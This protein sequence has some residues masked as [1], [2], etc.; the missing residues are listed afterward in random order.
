[1]AHRWKHWFWQWRGVAIAT[2]TVALVVLLLRTAGMLQALEWRAYD[3]FL[4]WRPQ[5]T[6]PRIA[7]VGI[8]EED[9]SLLGQ[10]ILPDEI[11]AKVIQTLRAQKPRAIGLDIYRDVPVEP[12]HAELVEVFTSTPNLVGIRK[13][14]GETGRDTVAA[15]PILAELGQVGV[16][17]LLADADN[18]V[19]RGMLQATGPEGDLLPSFALYLALLY[20]DAEGVGPEMIGE[21]DNWQ[22]GKTIFRPFEPNDGAYVRANAE[23]YQTLINYRGGAQLFETVPLRAV[24]NDELP[25]DWARDRIILV[26]PV[27]ESFKDLFFTP[28]S[29]ELLAL[30]EQMP[31]VEI[32]A[33]LTS[34]ILSA[35]LDGR[36]LIRSWPELLEVL[37]II[38][39]A[40]LGAVLTWVQR[41]TTAGFR[42]QR[43]W[44]LCLAALSL[45]A[46]THALLVL[47]WWVP[48]VPPLIALTGATVG[49][50]AYLAHGANQIRRTF[51]RYLSDQVV[52]NLLE[53]PEKLKLGGENRVIT[54]L[55]SDIRGFTSLSERLRPEQ[56]VEVLNLYLGFMSDVINRYGGTIDEFMGDG[57]L[58]LFGAPNHQ[59]DAPDRAVA[60]AI[61]M[62]QVMPQVNQVMR[63]RSFPELEMGIGINTGEVV[64]GN[65]GSEKRTKYSV[66][67]SAVNLAYRIE[68]YTTGG[69]ILVSDHTLQQVVSPVQVQDQQTVHPKGVKLPL[70]IHDIKGIGDPYNLTLTAA[71]MQMVTLANPITVTYAILDGKQVNDQTTQG[72]LVKLSDKGAWLKPLSPD[73]TLTKLTN[74]R[75]SVHSSH[76]PAEVSQADIYAK[77]QST[78]DASQCQIVFTARSQPVIDWIKSRLAT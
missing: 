60:C 39:W 17:D 7:I 46:I 44:S 33:N 67:G 64:V 4:R 38:G 6:D 73:S 63:D 52:A 49:V 30:P 69:Q 35:A 68:S 25:P 16:N 14:A 70:T 37:W 71:A 19:R 1:M 31:G 42:P 28:Y 26:G 40:A 9:V 75:L 48:V 27:S 78:I 8:D 53:Y 29:S 72:M 65:I 23:G 20:L 32:H 34:Q 58:V 47:G 18:T 62:Q 5:H 76:A 77:V 3:Q 50:T 74:L 66:I 57:I 61:A 41:D 45:V 55:T 51:G 12:G 59:S 21:T 22:L 11:Y 10:S 2:P 56:V 36:P 13:L 24:L 15:S 43:V 54:L